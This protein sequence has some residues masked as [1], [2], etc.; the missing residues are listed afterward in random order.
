M[1]SQ[2]Y[3]VYACL[4]SLIPRPSPS[5]LSLPSYCKRQEAEQGP[6]NEATCLYSNNSSLKSYWLLG[7]EAWKVLRGC[8]FEVCGEKWY[9]LD[10][11]EHCLIE[12]EHVNEKWR[13][14]VRRG[15][16]EGRR[17]GGGE[18]GRGE[19]GREGKGREGGG[20]KQKKG[21]VK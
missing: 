1:L 3:S 19:G 5:F 2:Q 12:E 17:E 16:E 6:G 11:K 20:K 21:V 9:P 18:G 10:E 15:K 8:W 7:K 13:E 4:V 14:Q